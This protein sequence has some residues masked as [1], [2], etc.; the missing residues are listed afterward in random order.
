MRLDGSSV[1]DPLE[2]ARSQERI[3]RF[4]RLVERL[5]VTAPAR[6]AGFEVVIAIVDPDGADRRREVVPGDLGDGSER[7]AGALHD[8]GGY[9]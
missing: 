7:V 5:L 8:Q 9:P 2:A 1:A 3:D 4:S 6:L